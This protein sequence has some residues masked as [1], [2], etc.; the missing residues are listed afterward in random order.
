[1]LKFLDD[2][3]KSSLK[4]GVIVHLFLVLCQ[5][6]APS[7]RP[8]PNPKN[9][10]SSLIVP[11]WWP[12]AHR[13]MSVSQNCSIVQGKQ[14]CAHCLVWEVFIPFE[15]KLPRNSC[16]HVFEVIIFCTRFDRNT[17]WRSELPSAKGYWISLSS[18]SGAKDDDPEVEKFLGFLFY[19]QPSMEGL[20]I[21]RFVFIWYESQINIGGISS[22]EYPEIQNL[23]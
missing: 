9:S 7:W 1:M 2:I 10:E 5:L 23:L 11:I 16:L 3:N 18:E 22:R 19:L 21:C 14:S 8:L 6:N 4:L 17:A 20:G 15:D 12:M 13:G